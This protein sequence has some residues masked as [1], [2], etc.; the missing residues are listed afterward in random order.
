MRQSITPY[1]IVHDGSEAKDAD[2]DI[3]LLAH[4][5]GVFQGP[6]ARESTVPGG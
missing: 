1:L 3:I 4:Q 6:A 5:A 2:M